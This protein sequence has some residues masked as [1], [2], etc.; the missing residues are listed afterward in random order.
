MTSPLTE[1]Q[2]M[3]VQTDI[4][5]QDSMGHQGFAL[6]TTTAAQSVGYVAVQIVS[7][8]VFTSI[9]GTGISGTWTG[10]TIPAGF[11]IV[12]RITSFQLTSGTVIAY[13]AR[14]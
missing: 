6:V 10:T 11:T 5:A 4:A 8:A 12:G 3:A 9:T 13:L 1:T 2:F 14:A 7:A